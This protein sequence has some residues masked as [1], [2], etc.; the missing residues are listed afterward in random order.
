[1]IE[2]N[3]NTYVLVSVLQSEAG[4]SDD[5][6]IISLFTKFHTNMTFELQEERLDMGSLTQSLIMKLKEG[7]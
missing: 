3:Y 4:S 1:M 5:Q 6:E 7:M 2:Q